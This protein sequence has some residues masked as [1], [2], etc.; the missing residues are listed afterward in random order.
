MEKVNTYGL[1]MTGLKNAVSTMKLI[2]M[3]VKKRSHY[4]AADRVQIAYN[5][6]TGEIYAEIISDPDYHGWKKYN[7]ENIIDKVCIYANAVCPAHSMQY[8]ADKIA[9]AVKK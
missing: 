4:D 5:K 6:K 3:R 8:I 2:D 1:K 7:D 9:E